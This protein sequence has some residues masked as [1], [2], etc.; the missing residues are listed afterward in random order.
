MSG[1]YLIVDVEKNEII[2]QFFG[3][4]DDAWNYMAELEEQDKERDVANW[5]LFRMV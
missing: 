5:F 1:T 3:S 4:E 2:A